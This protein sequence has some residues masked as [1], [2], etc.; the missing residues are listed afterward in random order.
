L[1]LFTFLFNGIYSYL[2]D[3]GFYSTQKTHY[4]MFEKTQRNS[5][6]FTIDLFVVIK[7]SISESSRKI[8]VTFFSL[9]NFLFHLAQDL[10]DKRSL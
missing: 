1:F 2:F 3:A 9:E 7:K 10:V 6:T 8:I 5:F 4:K